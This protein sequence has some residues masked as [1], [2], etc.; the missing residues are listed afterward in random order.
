MSSPVVHHAQQEEE[1]RAGGDGGSNATKLT[2]GQRD[3]VVAFAQAPTACER[4]GQE[5]ENE[6]PDDGGEYE[7]NVG[8]SRNRRGLR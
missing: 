7:E 2:A 5:P 6:Q 3:V 8:E 1:Q 4:I